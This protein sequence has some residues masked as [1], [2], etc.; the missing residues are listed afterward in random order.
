MNSDISKRLRIIM[1][2][3]Q[4]NKNSL[5]KK[6]GYTNNNMTV[7]KIL[8]S[9]SSPSYKTLLKIMQTFSE[10]NGHWL[11]TGEGE[12][13]IESSKIV[14]EPAP[15]YNKEKKYIIEMSETLKNIE[16]ILKSSQN[17]PK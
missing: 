14:S 16:E 12:M 10:I 13:F 3:Y 6:L 9:D 1:N 8:E 17:R 5:S 11:L 2:H 4:L 7:A 15:E